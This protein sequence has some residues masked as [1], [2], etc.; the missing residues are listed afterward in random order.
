MC[1]W[2][3][4]SSSRVAQE[5]ADAITR[6]GW[7]FVIWLMVF[8]VMDKLRPYVT[9]Q[10]LEEG[11]SGGMEEARRSSLSYRGEARTGMGSSIRSQVL[12]AYPSRHLRC[13]YGS[14]ATRPGGC[15]GRA[16]SDWPNP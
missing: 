11:A 4:W 6:R 15:D 3:Q 9:G 16:K 12:R 10:E 13:L 5:G 1:P 14:G 8:N 7:S 2:P